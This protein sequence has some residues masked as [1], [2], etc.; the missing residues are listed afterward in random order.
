M[1]ELK[2]FM[3]LRESQWVLIKEKWW[4][5][6]KKMRLD[7]TMAR[8]FAK[9]LEVYVKVGRNEFF[10]SHRVGD[11][12]FIAQRCS[13]QQSMFMELVE[14]YRG[15]RQNCI[16]VPEDIDGLGWRKMVEMLKEIG[17]EGGLGGAAP[18]MT[19]VEPL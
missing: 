18:T 4:K 7:L 17:R 9:A 19:L 13:N 2:L 3:V 1:I 6:V 5:L 12:G 15:G 14:Y 16:F 11:R 8:R 10:A